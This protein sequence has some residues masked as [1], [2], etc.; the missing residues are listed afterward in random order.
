MSDIELVQGLI[1][2]NG[3]CIQTFL[4]RFRS[5]VYKNIDLIY[6]KLSVPAPNSERVKEE[7]YLALFDNLHNNEDKQLKDFLQDEHKP[8]LENWF[9]NVKLPDFIPDKIIV[10]GLLNYDKDITNMYVASDNEYSLQST[11]NLDY[12]GI[13][14]PDVDKAGQPMDRRKIA[15]EI[16]EIL[17]LGEEKLSGIKEENI[18]RNLRLFKFESSLAVYINK[19]IPAIKRLSNYQRGSSMTGREKD[20]PDN[21]ERKFQNCIEVEIDP[22]ELNSF[23]KKV[24]SRMSLSDKGRRDALY[25]EEHHLKRMKV[26]D[27]AVI[28]GVSVEDMAVKVHRARKT[29]RDICCHD[30]G[31]TTYHQIEDFY[32]KD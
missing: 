7:L 17:I 32:G 2:R 25:L 23:I 20:L 16:Y 28:H 5:D 30:F 19:L 10:D 6:G 24:F 13:L 14:I 1:D 31:A 9:L 8:S 26:K 3:V 12:L 4:D 18:G 11:V 15:T 21:F 22:D 29:F 27:M